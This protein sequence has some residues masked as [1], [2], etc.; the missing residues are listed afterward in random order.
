[1]TA[2]AIANRA[3]G[4]DRWRQYLPAAVMLGPLV[5]FLIAFYI[6]P[7]G[8]MLEESLRWWQGDTPPAGAEAVTLH[9]YEKTFESSRSS[10][11]IIRT[12][13]ISAFSVLFAFLL[14]YP[15]ALLLLRVGRQLRSAILLVTFISLA[16]SLIVRNYGWLVVLADQGPVN[17]ILVWLGVFDYPQRMVYNEWAIVI[18]LVH[19]CLPFMILPI[20]G[21][22]LR[23]PAS[24]WEA[25]RTLGAGVWRSLAT[26]ILPLSMPGIFGGTML[27]FAVCMSAFVTPLMLG[28]PSTAM[29]SQVAAEQL[30]VQLNFAWGSAIIFVLTAV[31]FVIVL[32]YALLVRRVMRVHV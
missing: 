2:E 1:M 25:P 31:T 20:Y 18:A 29:V 15:V 6:V 14:S 9:Q 3:P 17:N 26:V 16:A 4:H 23:I 13:R 32:V 28:S 7:F 24:Y 8:V 30:L 19:Y 21:S 11:A 12:L 10:R 22:L 27:S 5:V